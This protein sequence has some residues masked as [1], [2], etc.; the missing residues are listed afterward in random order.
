MN[1]CLRLGSN[2]VNFISQQPDGDLVCEKM[3][4]H[5]EKGINAEFCYTNQVWLQRSVCV[6]V[7]QSYGDL[8]F[9]IWHS[10][11]TFCTLMT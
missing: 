11:T 1:V 5:I 9:S 8:S 2:A 10:M 7:L 3:K 6:Y 4:I